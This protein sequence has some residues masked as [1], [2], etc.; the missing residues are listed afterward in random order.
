[1]ADEPACVAVASSYVRVAWSLHAHARQ[2]A[3]AKSQ[4][5]CASALG[6]MQVSK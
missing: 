6:T 2:D 5:M 4:H 1:M 3:K